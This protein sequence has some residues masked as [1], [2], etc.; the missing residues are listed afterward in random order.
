M[1]YD[2]GSTAWVQSNGLQA[3]IGMRQLPEYEKA[4]CA[5]EDA[6]RQLFYYD[7][8]DLFYPLNPT[9]TLDEDEQDEYDSIMGA[10]ST[11]AE[12][13]MLK[14]FTGAKSMDEYDAFVETLKSMGIERATELENEAYEKYAANFK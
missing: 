5:S 3:L 12:E 11:Y 14:F 1:V 7:E 2:F 4:Q 6:C 9:L 13:E 10:I 8:N